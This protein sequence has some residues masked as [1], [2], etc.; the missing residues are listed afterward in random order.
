MMD[1]IFT[2]N[3]IYTLYKILV[4]GFLFMQFFVLS[5]FCDILVKCL[6]QVCDI[7]D[8]NHVLTHAQ[9]EKVQNFCFGNTFQVLSK[10]LMT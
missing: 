1:N 5:R 8:M 4:L 9:T 6:S 2:N 3:F 10:K 7:F